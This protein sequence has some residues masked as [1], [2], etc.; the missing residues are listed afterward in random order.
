MIYIK[1]FF[2]VYFV[3][4]TYFGLSYKMIIFQNYI[5]TEPKWCAGNQTGVEWS[6]HGAYS[7]R[8]GYQVFSVSYGTK[9]TFICIYLLLKQPEEEAVSDNTETCTCRYC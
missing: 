7:R 5:V 3:L 8:V 9:K 1:H 6:C 2:C 4:I